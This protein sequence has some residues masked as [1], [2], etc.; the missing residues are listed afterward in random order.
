MSIK[1]LTSVEFALDIILRYKLQTKVVAVERKNKC[2]LE[3][4]PRKP[5]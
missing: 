4:L 1:F 5:E 2:R 3:K